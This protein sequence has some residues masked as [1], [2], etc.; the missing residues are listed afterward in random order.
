M[1][2]IHVR[3]TSPEHPRPTPADAVRV[4][5]ALWAHTPKTAG[6]EHIRARAGPDGIDLVLFVRNPDCLLFGSAVD[7][8]T[9]LR[10]GLLTLRPWRIVPTI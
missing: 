1:L 3:L 8:P 7:I 6:L 2:L 5:D 4:H 9:P 10:D